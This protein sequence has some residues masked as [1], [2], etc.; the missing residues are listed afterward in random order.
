MPEST[1]GDQGGT[2]A[3]A[4]HED[5]VKRKFREAL[6]RKRGRPADAVVGARGQEGSKV[7]GTHGKAGGQRSFRRKSG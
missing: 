5:E 2:E 4:T 7:H 1:P 3:G 6:D